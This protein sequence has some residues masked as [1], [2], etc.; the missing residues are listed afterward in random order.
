MLSAPFFSFLYLHRFTSFL[1]ATDFL[2]KR[3]KHLVIPALHDR[4]VKF[5]LHFRQHGNIPYQSTDFG[6]GAS[7]CRDNPFHRLGT[8]WVFHALHDMI[9]VYL[10]SFQF[11]N[12]P[13]SFI[14]FRLQLSFIRQ[15]LQHFFLVHLQF[16]QLP[17]S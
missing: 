14:A 10:F 7:H 17:L 13:A 3:E 15:N 11:K 4:V 2:V 6:K 8:L 5:L 1:P 12:T 9:R 16:K